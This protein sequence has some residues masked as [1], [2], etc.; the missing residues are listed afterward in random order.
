M[1]N[2]YRTKMA[3]AGTVGYSSLTDKEQVGS[4]VKEWCDKC[5]ADFS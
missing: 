2:D 1:H 3:G 5:I 4:K